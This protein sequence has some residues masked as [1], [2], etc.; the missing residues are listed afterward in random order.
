ML[1]AL[2][3][4]F[5]LSRDIA[6]AAGQVATAAKGLAV[7]DLDQQITVRSGDEL[8]QMAD[9]VR[10]M[11]AYQHEMAEVARAKTLHYI[12]SRLL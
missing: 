6:R 5:F 1:L 11:I 3:I 10:S 12:D 7:G 4:G 9:A 8:G 2:L